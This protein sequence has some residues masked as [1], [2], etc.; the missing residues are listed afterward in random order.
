MKKLTAFI[1]C[2]LFVVCVNAQISIHGYI[3]NAETLEPIPFATVIINNSDRG[4]SCDKDGYYKLI[5]NESSEVQLKIS[6]VGFKNCSKTILTDNRKTIRQ[7]CLLET[8]T[9]EL[10]EISVT[11]NRFKRKQLE[12]PSSINS[13]SVKDLEILSA[14]NTDNLLQAIPNV[15]VNR[16]WGIFSKNS[17]VTMR[18]MDG[19]SRVLVLYNGVPL[20]KTAGGGINWHII[21]PDQIEKIEVIKGP[22]S[23]MYGNN[24]MAGVINIISKTPNKEI[25]GSVSANYGTFNTLGGRFNLYGN[26]VRD[27]KGFYYNIESFYR[28]GDGYIIEPYDTRDSTDVALYLREVSVNSKFGFQFNKDSKVELEYQFYTDTRG[29]GRKVV[30]TDGGYLKYPTHY[31]RS[32]YE[33]KMYGI[34][35]NTHV[36]YHQQDYFQHSER[37]NQTGTTYKLYD[38]TN[39]TRDFGLWISGEKKF[40]DNHA[41]I[42]GIDTKKRNY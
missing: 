37:L 12:V 9:H 40:N 41:L 4:T 27:F 26:Q 28:Q 5:I 3:K 24:A 16:S 17:S 1:F 23:A 20:N 8:A 42:F 15:Y 7:D 6:S 22:A 2:L 39:S 31:L 38:R 35:F 34:N 19:T 25:G 21:N 32:S 30:E 10:N 13:I 36:F 33:T 18:G 11:A 29:D 14:T